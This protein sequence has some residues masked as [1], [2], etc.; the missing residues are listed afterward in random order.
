MIPLKCKTKN[1]IFYAALKRYERVATKISQ[2]RDFK[3]Y[4]TQT[5]HRKLQEYF[6]YLS[7][8]EKNRL[9]K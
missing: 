2:H 3:K 5:W 7:N 9:V 4:E 8:Y 6:A 1:Q